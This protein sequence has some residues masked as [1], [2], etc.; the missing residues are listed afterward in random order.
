MAL[1]GG[2]YR[3]KGVS[4]LGAFPFS[5]RKESGS[6]LFCRTFSQT[7]DGEGRKK[8]PPIPF[9]SFLRI[10]LYHRPKWVNGGFG[11][12][13]PMVA[14][15]PPGPIGKRRNYLLFPSQNKEKYE[16]RNFLSR[17]FLRTGRKREIKEKS[18][19]ANLV[20]GSVTPSSPRA[21]I[22]SF[23]SCRAKQSGL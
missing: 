5:R 14:G 11:L 13:D 6:V 1:F 15:S 12:P 10:L 19:D 9:P 2:K 8:L 21:G 22:S 4:F 7:R 18:S 17:I 20:F 3:K 23:L 16:S